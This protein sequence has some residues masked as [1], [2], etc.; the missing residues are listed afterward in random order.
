VVVLSV[1]SHEPG[2]A[3]DEPAEFFEKLA[4]EAIDA[5]AT[6][7]VGHGPHRLRG[8]EVYKG[9][10]ILYSVGNFL[11][12]LE[13]GQPPPTDPYDTGADMYSLA[14]GIPGAPAAGSFGPGSDA[15]WEGIV[16]VATFEAGALRSLQVHPVDL[17]GD[18]PP[19]RRGVPR[20]PAAPRAARVLERLARLSQP[21]HT[22]IRIESGIGTVE[23]K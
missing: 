15:W 22:T 18:L 23:I 21:Y 14:T 7:V 9:G 19:N 20:T 17:G 5:G 3:S 16:A 6:L 8:V 4:R 2:N 11:Y 12:Q 1:H 13:E 10:G